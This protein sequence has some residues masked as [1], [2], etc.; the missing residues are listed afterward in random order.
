[1]TF[2]SGMFQPEKE[3]YVKQCQKA[4]NILPARWASTRRH[5]D[6]DVQH[7]RSQ[8]VPTYIWAELRMLG[9]TRGCGFALAAIIR[10]PALARRR[11]RR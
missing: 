11:R 5:A 1:M 8:R 6:A 2:P 4:I 9:R 7:R 3:R 10:A